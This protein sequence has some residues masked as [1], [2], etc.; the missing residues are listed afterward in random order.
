MKKINILGTEYSIEQ[1]SPKDNELLRER[2]GYCDKTVKKIVVDTD[3]EGSNLQD[4]SEYA[5]KVLRHEIIHAFFE[6]SGLAENYEHN[7]AGIE[8]TIVDWIAIQFPK[9]KRV[10]E[11]AECL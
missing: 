3:S 5:K 7:E 8:E 10:F 2:S 6:E 1:S 9:I 4:Y 11:E